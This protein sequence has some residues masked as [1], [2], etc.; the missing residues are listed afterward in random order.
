MH[1]TVW[2]AAMRLWRDG[3]YREA[4]A[5]AAE[6]VILQVKA[7]TRRNDVAEAALWQETFSDRDP[8]PGKPRLRW[9]GDPTDRDVATMNAGL[10]F[11]APGV[12]LTVR[13]PATHGAG[14]LDEQAAVERLSTLSLLAR[15]VDECDLVEA[16]EK[17][18]APS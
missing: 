17:S 10:R 18:V 2:G 8:V 14:E 12:Q 16:S 5:A 13:N 7:R 3:H 9:P 11:F 6:A 4:V 1:P 15:W